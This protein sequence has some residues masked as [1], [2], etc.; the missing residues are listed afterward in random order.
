MHTKKFSSGFWSQERYNS[1][2]KEK[3]EWN[4]WMNYSVAGKNTLMENM[5]WRNSLK[6][7]SGVKNLNSQWR[8]AGKKGYAQPWK[9][10]KWRRGLLG[11]NYILP[12]V[13]GSWRGSGVVELDSQQHS[14]ELWRNGRDIIYSGRV[15]HATSLVSLNFAGRG[16]SEYVGFLYMKLWRKCSTPYSYWKK[17]CISDCRIRRFIVIMIQSL[18]PYVEIFMASPWRII[19]FIMDYSHIPPDSLNFW[20]ESLAALRLKR[21]DRYHLQC[22][23]LSRTCRTRTWLVNAQQHLA[24]LIYP[25]ETRGVVG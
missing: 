25:R 21:A 7:W 12:H 16:R 24:S 18:I 22:H 9:R 20:V 15:L 5:L 10:H 8:R 14:W 3:S 6:F 17:R 13:A 19:D 4:R 11:I 1:P 2:E 23:L